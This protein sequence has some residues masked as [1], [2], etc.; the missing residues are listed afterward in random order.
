[1]RLIWQASREV[2]ER[3]P[4][5]AG[6]D[7]AVVPNGFDA[8]DFAGPAPERSA[9]GLRIVHTGFL[10]TAFGSRRRN[11]VR[12]A[13]GGLPDGDPLTRS[14]VELPPQPGPIRI[15]VCGSTVYQRIHVGNS[16]PFVLA[17][18]IRSWLRAMGRPAV[19]RCSP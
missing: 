8:E 17:M 11:L 4:E 12:R 15:Y 9:C 10:H 6:K 14:H 5:L 13:M 2:R 16:R 3:F 1:M 18:W 19:W 7:V